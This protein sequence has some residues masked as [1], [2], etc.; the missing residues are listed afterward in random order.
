MSKYYIGNGKLWLMG[1]A[2]Y[3]EAIDKEKK[4]LLRSQQTISK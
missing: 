1:G 2:V 3:K 4:K